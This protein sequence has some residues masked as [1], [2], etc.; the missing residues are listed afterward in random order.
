MHFNY[1]HDCY[2]AQKMYKFNQFPYALNISFFLV[3]FKIS[4]Y[5]FYAALDYL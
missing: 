1:Y 2:A 3:F 5:T 4:I